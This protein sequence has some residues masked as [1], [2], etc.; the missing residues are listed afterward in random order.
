MKKYNI[1]LLAFIILIAQQTFAQSSRLKVANR[2]FE[3][4]SYIEAIR[5]YED[6]LRTAKTGT[7]EMKETLTKLA[8][9][10]RKVQDSRNA[11]RIYAEL[12]DYYNKD[13][14]SEI[15]LYFAQALANNG[16][17]KESQKMYSRYGQ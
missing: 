3:N 1:W 5:N 4:M 16:K 6:Y 8:Y 2:S 11:E 17:Y 10:Y 13:L 7:P 15:Y 14:E 9:S 12:I